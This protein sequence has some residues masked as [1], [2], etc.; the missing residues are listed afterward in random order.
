[1]NVRRGWII[2]MA[3][4]LLSCAARFSPL[5]QLKEQYAR[6]PEF[7]IILNDMK[8]EGNFFKDYYHQYKVIYAEPVA[9]NPD[10]LVYFTEIT[11]WYKVDRKTYEKYFN[12][13][14]MAL[15]SKTPDGQ[16]VDVQFPPGYQY[17]GNP[18]YGTW[19]TDAHGNSFWEFYGK[20]MFLSQMFGMFTRPIYQ[21]D[22]EDYRRYTRQGRPYFGRGNEYGTFGKIT[23]KTHRSFFERQQLKQQLKKQ[24]FADKVKQRVR[25][26]KMSGLRSRS[27]GFGK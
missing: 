25:R 23:K 26:S 19:R 11:D 8:E 9:E 3:A 14:G 18:R 4:L 12:F 22:W 7:T 21:S 2:L 16:I 1:M 10:S 20:Y 24:R 27:G 5:E 13:L 6:Y 17:V 15:L